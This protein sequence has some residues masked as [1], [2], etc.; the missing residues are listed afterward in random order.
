MVEVGR[1]IA[2]LSLDEGSCDDD[3]PDQAPKLVKFINMAVVPSLA[4]DGVT[5]RRELLGSFVGRRW[6]AEVVELVG[7]PEWQRAPFQASQS[8][9]WSSQEEY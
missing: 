7:L 6:S 8:R 5:T 1:N 3:L 2:V 4:I 9:R